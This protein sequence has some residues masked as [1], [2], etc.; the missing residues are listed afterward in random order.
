MGRHGGARAAAT[1][2]CEVEHSGRSSGA[3]AVEGE[4]VD[5]GVADALRRLVGELPGGGESRH[6]QME[7]AQSIAAAVK[8]GRHLIVRAGTGTGKTLGY[9]VPAIL[10]GKRVVVATATKALQDQ[11]ATKD[12]PFLQE[13]LDTTFDWAVLKGRSNYVCVQ[14]LAETAAG[15]TARAKRPPPNGSGGTATGAATD[16]PPAAGDGADASA[17]GGDQLALD[18]LGERADP[19]ELVAIAEWATRTQVG[20]RAEL[21]VEPSD[22][23]WA[24]VSTTSRDC[25]GANRCPRGAACFAE[26]ARSKAAESDVV[27]VNQHLYGLNLASAGAILP[28]HDLCV[29]DEAHVLDDVISATCGIEI[30]IGRF[31]HLSRMLRGIL[32]Q[33]EAV[34]DA[35]DTAGHRLLGAAVPH[36]D[37]RLVPPMP[38]ALAAALTDARQHVARAQAALGE[39]PD[40]APDDSVA[41]ATRARQA[42]TALMDDLAALSQPSS[43]DVVWVEGSDRAPV[44][45]LAPLDVAGLL[46]AALWDERAAVLTSATIPAGFGRQVGLPPEDEVPLDVGSPFDYEH[47][48]VIYCASHLPRPT[49]PDWADAAVDELGT[50]IEAAEGRTLALFTSYKAMGHAID[51]LGE[52]LPYPLLAQGD[53]PKARLIDRFSAEPET[54][55]FATMSFWQGIDVPGPS[56]SLVTIDRLPFPRPDEPLLQARRERVGAA[57]F[58]TIDV[59]RAATMLAQGVGRLIRTATDKGA[60]AVFDPRL[61]T[62]RYGP[63]IVAA[64]PKMRRTKS[65]DEVVAFLRSLRS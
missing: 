51:R 36:R 65:R 42:A 34:V 2:C 10:S 3:T 11:L 37:Q 22:A 21:L 44:L 4:D 14:R 24:A 55:L 57:A 6:G 8:D 47:N 27:V 49:S 39:L 29:V 35:V 13:H 56:L 19:D 28:E 23:T 54:C 9:L 7:M 43:G 17:A 32:A 52:R 62:A 59:P 1:V 12:L 45:R 30:G 18:G 48:A 40:A 26:R 50:L 16:P 53:L 38:D 61:A 20:D 15:L 41:R 5:V 64:L 46:R 31:T 60:V 33:A 25:P 58:L 63:K